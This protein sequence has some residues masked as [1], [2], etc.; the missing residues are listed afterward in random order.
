MYLI[1]TSS[2]DFTIR[3]KTLRLVHPRFACL[4]SV[5]KILFAGIQLVATTE[6]LEHLER[7]DIS[8]IAPFVK[9]VAFIAPPNSCTLTYDSFR[10]MVVAQT[11]QRYGS[12]HQIQ[13]YSS[14]SNKTY[15]G[16]RKV[17][18]QHWDGDFPLS[19]KQIR[20]KFDRYHKDGLVAIDL[21]QGEGLR[22]AWTTALCVIP[23]YLH[24]LF[25]TVKYDVLRCSYI[26]VQPNCLVRQDY[27]DIDHGRE[28]YMGVTGLLSD[29]LFAAAI[30]CLAN[31][32]VKVRKLTVACAMTGHFQ[33]ETLPGWEACDFS[34]VQSF[35]FLPQDSP[36]KEDWV[37]VLEHE[38]V[39]AERAADAI[40]AILKKC[41]D[42]LEKLMLYQWACPMRWPGDEV[43]PLP[44]LKTLWFPSGNRGYIRPRNLKAW[45]A[46]MPSLEHFACVCTET[47]G[48][49]DEGWMEVFDAIRNHPR[50]MK[51]EFDHITAA[52]EPI[53]LDYHTDD[54]QGHL[55][56]EA[57]EEPWSDVHQRAEESFDR[58]EYDDGTGYPASLPLYLS[59]KIDMDA[60]TRE[61]LRDY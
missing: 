23:N 4:H 20:Q 39:I 14:Y 30:A 50:G 46:K 37:E 22:A 34:Q 9:K 35:K 33:W 15:D 5:L 49:G 21:L 38:D 42:S 56:N 31:A 41:N 52:G 26:P 16:H 58:P 10:E 25:S 1:D 36:N 60:A 28:T 13:K 3:L 51:V 8:H 2:S 44:K 57:Q 47:Q 40:A 55:D 29:A 7:A 43:I 6:H 18:E 59:G 45:M 53:T 12:D 24:L 19:D 32:D 27:H 54:F 61:L 11:I 17:I 48:S